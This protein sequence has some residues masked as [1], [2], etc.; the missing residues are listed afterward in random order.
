MDNCTVHGDVE[1]LKC[2]EIV[3][4]LPSTISLMQPCDMSVIRALKA[5]FR[6]EMRARIIDTF[7][8]ESDTNVN[9]NVVAKQVFVL[10]G[11][12]MLLD[13]W[14]K[15][16]NSTIRNCWRRANFVFCA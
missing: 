15:V 1:D 3:K 10:D 5:Y 6:H 13:S 7:D 9:A 8:D 11:L 14:F 16:T 12:H 4:L 2:I